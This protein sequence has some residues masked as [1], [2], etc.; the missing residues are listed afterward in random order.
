MIPLTLPEPIA[1]LAR[2]HAIELGPEWVSDVARLGDAIE[3]VARARQDA[4]GTA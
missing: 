3:R 2:R 1:A 4:L